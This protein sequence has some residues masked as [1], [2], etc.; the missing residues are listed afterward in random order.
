MKTIAIT[1]NKFSLY[2]Y[3]PGLWQ[4]PPIRKP[5]FRISKTNVN[6]RILVKL[7]GAIRSGKTAGTIS[8][9]YRAYKKNL[10][11]E[12]GEIRVETRLSAS[13]SQGTLNFFETP[14]NYSYQHQKVK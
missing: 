11:R 9:P 3:N 2:R 13:L 5:Y 7:I 4:Y 1:A 12:G 14:Y 6:F 8:N 10:S